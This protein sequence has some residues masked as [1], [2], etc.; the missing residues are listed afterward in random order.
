ME[1]SSSAT[2]TAGA[3]GSHLNPL[4]ANNIS[5]V[6]SWQVQR[7]KQPAA[8]GQEVPGARGVEEGGAETPAVPAHAA[9]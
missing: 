6:A 9:G 7:P 2:G 1:A 8:A 4:V 3:N 5:A